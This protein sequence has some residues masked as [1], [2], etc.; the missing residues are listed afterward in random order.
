M[1]A[2]TPRV[3]ICG[4]EEAASVVVKYDEKAPVPCYDHPT[5]FAGMNAR[6]DQYSTAALPAGISIPTQVGPVIEWTEARRNQG[7][8]HFSIVKTTLKHYANPYTK[9]DLGHRVAHTRQPL[10]CGERKRARV[11]LEFIYLEN[12][13]IN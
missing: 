4:F 13:Y 8:T 10:D 12:F 1:A 3:P 6:I 5:S 11:R 2:I 9:L 7:A